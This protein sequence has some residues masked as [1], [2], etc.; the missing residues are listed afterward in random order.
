L[1]G[2]LQ[3][4]GAVPTAD[5]YEKLIKECAKLWGIFTTSVQD[6][7]NIANMMPLANKLQKIGAIATADAYGRLILLFRVPQNESAPT[8]ALVVGGLIAH[9]FEG[10]P[11]DRY[12]DYR[13]FV[14]LAEKALKNAEA[15]GS[16][17]SRECAS[18]SLRYIT[19]LK[20]V[21]AILESEADKEALMREYSKG[22]QRREYIEYVFSA[23][24][25]TIVP[26]PQIIEQKDDLKAAVEQLAKISCAKPG[27]ALF[28]EADLRI[29]TRNVETALLHALETAPQHIRIIAADGLESIGSQRVKKEL[30][31]I[32]TDNGEHTSIGALA[33]STLARMGENEMAARYLVSDDVMVPPAKLRRGPSPM[34]PPFTKGRDRQLSGL[35][36][37]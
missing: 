34:P 25:R 19:G 13:Q 7:I 23:V 11:F 4:A 1:A 30:E 10:E 32:A 29:I 2:K 27:N 36:R 24:D 14:L 3:E 31:R 37:N 15:N 5:A 8:A 22:T 35:V 26:P 20:P 16:A 6:D 17:D 21:K 12:V 28:C 18:T 33:S 9:A